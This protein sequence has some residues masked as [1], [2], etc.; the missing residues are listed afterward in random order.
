[1]KRKNHWV[2]EFKGSNLSY[3]Q[4]E[5]ETDMDWSSSFAVTVQVSGGEA[6]A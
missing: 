5:Y 3:G 1:M 2:A 4:R 6:G